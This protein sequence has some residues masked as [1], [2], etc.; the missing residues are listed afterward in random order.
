MVLGDGY[1]YGYIGQFQGLIKNLADDL[2]DV[3]P[4]PER[5]E[6]RAKWLI[7]TLARMGFFS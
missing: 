3:E 5:R 1:G 4:N 2:A 6:Q 7:I